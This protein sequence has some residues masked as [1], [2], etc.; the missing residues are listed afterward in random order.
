MAGKTHRIG[1]NLIDVSKIFGT[2]D[3][4]RAYL[5]AMRWP[6]GVRCIKCG[7]N[8]ISKFVTKGRERRDIEGV[9]VKR[10]P[11]RHLYQC[12][13]RECRYQ[14]TV[15]DGTIFN[16]THLPLNKWF[17]ATAMMCNAKKGVSAK[18]MER[19]L[20]VSYKTA[21]YLCHRIRKA[22]SSEGGLFD[23][24]VEVDATYI[25]GKYDKRRKREPWQD[26]PAVAGLVQRDTETEHSKV[27]ALHVTGET[28]EV[29]LPLV[30]NRTTEQTK[31]YTDDRPTY[32]TLRNTRAHDIVIHSHN[33]YVRGSA[34]T[35][36]VENFW[37]NFKRGVIGSFHQVS[38]KHLQRY[39][40]EFQFR[41]NNRREQKIFS[42]VVLNLVIQTGIK[43]KVL[44]GNPSE[45]ES[46]DVPF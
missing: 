11:D 19:D 21:W 15:T 13:D 25:G 29:M 24:E 46:S 31:I 5:E 28:K 26:K 27:I 30:Q 39:L 35:N 45:P 8:K 14:F 22:M 17:M 38:I 44:T 43:Y 2:E 10:S 33:E 42:M 4:C 36:S 12:L 37:S 9:I 23:G 18:Q 40:D 32:H 20:G 3:A 41:F 7:S 1:P 16:D 6:T 34:H